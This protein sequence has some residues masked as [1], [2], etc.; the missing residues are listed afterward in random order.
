MWRRCR[1]RLWR[2]IAWLLA[3]ALMLPLG[4]CRANPSPKLVSG[5]AFLL[6]TYVAITLYDES[7]GHLIEECFDLIEQYEQKL[8][9]TIA[10]SEIAR[11]NKRTDQTVSADTAA[12]LEKALFFSDV[13]G[14]AFDVT[15]GSVSSLWDFTAND[16]AVPANADIQAALAHVDFRGVAIDGTAVTFAD[17]ETMLDLGAVAKGFIADRVKEYLVDKGVKHGIIDLGGNLLCIGNR[18][19]DTPYTIGVQDPRSERGALVL[20][21]AVNDRSVVTSGIYER[22]FEQD[23]KTYHHILDP[24]TGYPIDNELDSVTIIS[25]HSVDGDGYSTACMAMGLKASQ[26]LINQT[27]GIDAI[28]ITRDGQIHY[29][30]GLTDRYTISK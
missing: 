4:G 8:S 19:D 30:D 9:R 15:I 22:C 26:A 24:Q 20:T 1:D 16:P 27:D 14:G 23:G 5:N 2:P 13:S 29:S 12:L 11:L 7:Q 25:R 6:N 17:D 3:A 28:W 21:V 18:P 10:S